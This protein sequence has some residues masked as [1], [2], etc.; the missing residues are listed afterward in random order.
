MS[1]SSESSI[2]YTL[3]DMI[4][5][6]LTVNYKTFYATTNN[7]KHSSVHYCQAA[8]RGDDA[9]T[10][11]LFDHSSSYFN[12]PRSNMITMFEFRGLEKYAIHIQDVLVE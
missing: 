4:I 11:H 7:V 12:V 5:S 2:V 1:C 8:M 3:Q 9:K 6:I 10:N